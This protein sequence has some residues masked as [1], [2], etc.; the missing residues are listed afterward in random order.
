MDRELYV[1]ADLNGAAHLVGR[2]WVRFV[3]RRESATFEYDPAWLGNP[4]RFELEPALTL[5]SGPHHARAGK[6]LFGAFGDSAP[7]RWGR[8][9]LQ[10]EERRKAAAERR[11]PNTLAEVDYLIGVGDTARMGALRFAEG[12]GGPFLATGEARQI[13]PIVQLGALLN[14]AQNID[15][16]GG[17]DEDLRILLAPGGSLGGARPK[18]AVIDNDG[19][20]SIAK[21]PKRDE[22][23]DVIGWE[24]LA[25]TLSTK[26]GLRTTAWRIERPT[27]ASALIVRRFDRE[28]AIRIP[29][30]SAMSMLD[31][32]D[33][34]L[35]SYLE[36]ADALRQYGS[37]PVGDCAELW[38][39][40][41]FSILISNTDDHL[42]N[43]GFLYDGQ[44]GGWRLAP[45]YDVN[46]T[47]ETEQPRILSTA[48]NED[49]ATASLDLAFEVADYF[50]VKHSA[51]KEVAREVGRVVSTWRDEAA[52]LGISGQEIERMA[53]AFE[54]HDLETSLRV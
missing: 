37:D 36:L 24:A 21:F 28:G 26:S 40:I 49:D 11:R 38:R 52:R 10:R 34:D 23:H 25:L 20:V 48:I 12:L 51:A 50:G 47:P 14:A 45:V 22:R 44:G 27:T 5:G 33:G 42:R 43:H 19:I 53:S 39:K 15:E 7:D 35:R 8:M 46:P 41:V 29:F 16:D 17:T 54:H 6:A 13:P 30:L 9:L 4:L 31:A 1:Y 18:A 3:R 32:S 2:L